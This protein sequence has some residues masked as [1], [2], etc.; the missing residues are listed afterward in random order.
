MDG[1]MDGWMYVWM[2]VCMHH[3]CCLCLLHTQSTAVQFCSHRDVSVPR[4]WV[5]TYVASTERPQETMG[6]NKVSFLITRE[7][8]DTKNNAYYYIILAEA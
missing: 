3:V 8:L 7:D 6:N 4:S 2:Y 1:W 5:N